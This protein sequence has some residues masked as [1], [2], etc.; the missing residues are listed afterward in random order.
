M[1]RYYLDGI[2]GLL[3]GGVGDTITTILSLPI[4]YFCVFQVRSIPLTLAVICNALIDV[5]LGLI[6]FFI[7]DVI[8][9]FYMSYLKNL[10]MIR[11]YVDGDKKIV[12]EVNRKAWIS[13]IL[14]V[15]LCVIIYF[16]IKLLIW[17]GGW[18]AIWLNQA[19]DYIVALF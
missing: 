14:I 16:L 10:K 1:D 7:G 13:A 17:L 9:F 11:G 8:D 6:P 18:I 15:V 19:Y 2:V 12:T 5:A 3:P 4:I